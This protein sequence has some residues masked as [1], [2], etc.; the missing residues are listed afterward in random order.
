[1]ATGQHQVSAP[2]RRSL[3]ALPESVP[4]LRAAVADG[5]DGLG[6]VVDDARNTEPSRVARV[7]SPEGPP[8]KVTVVPTNEELAIAR[9]TSA[10]IS[11]NSDD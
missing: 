5:L 1:V 8:I 6:I 11:A 3:P 7:I 4:A 2:L 10:L 9:E